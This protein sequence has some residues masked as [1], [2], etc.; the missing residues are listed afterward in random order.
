MM[1]EVVAVFA[2]RIW[3]FRTVK[4]SLGAASRYA[5]AG[6]GC[7]ISCGSIAPL[8]RAT[9][10]APSALTLVIPRKQHGVFLNAR[11]RWTKKACWM[12]L[13]GCR[14]W[15]HGKSWEGSGRGW[16]DIKSSAAATSAG[17]FFHTTDVAD[18]RR[19]YLSGGISRESRPESASRSGDAG[20]VLGLS[21]GVG[22]GGHI[23]MCL[24]GTGG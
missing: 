7:M 17:S 5:A 3:K 19:A 9:L 11:L 6:P 12:W 24:L 2:A 21:R 20:G 14:P 4:P 23:G 15:N 22:P 8:S 13:L 18:S 1:S 10:G 16:R